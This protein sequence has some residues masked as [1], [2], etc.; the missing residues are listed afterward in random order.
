MIITFR[1]EL[2]TLNFM[3]GFSNNADY[4][5]SRPVEVSVTRSQKKK[6]LKTRRPRIEKFK[7][8]LAYLG[9]KKWNLLPLDIHQSVDK[10]EFKRLTRNWVNQKALKALTA[11]S[12]FLN[13]QCPSSSI[14]N[15]KLSQVT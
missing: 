11:Q 8:S 10:W 3:Y 7:K 6:T 5:V 12:V 2:H 13:T 14:T 4:L 1:R 9:S 15:I